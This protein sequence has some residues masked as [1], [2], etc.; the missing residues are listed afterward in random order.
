[1]LTAI[2]VM[3]SK[4]FRFYVKVSESQVTDENVFMALK[5]F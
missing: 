5:L 4:K 3:S 1:M 2:A